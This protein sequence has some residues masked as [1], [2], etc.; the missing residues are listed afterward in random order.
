M[1][2]GSARRK[3]PTYTENSRIRTQDLSVG[4]GEDSSFLRFRGRCDRL[5]NEAYSYINKSLFPEV[6]I[7]WTDEKLLPLYGA[8]VPCSCEPTLRL[9]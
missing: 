2:G 9:D 6:F 1:D 3:V 4:P 8:V 7:F 5:W